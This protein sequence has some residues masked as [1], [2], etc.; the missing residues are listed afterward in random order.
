MEYRRALLEK[1]NIAQTIVTIAHDNT[2]YAHDSNRKIRHGY[3]AVFIKISNLIQKNA[4]KEDIKQYLD[5]VE[6]WK[7]FVEGE[8]KKSNETNNRSLG[9][10]Q[11]R[12]PNNEE[13]DNDNN[14]EVNMEKIMARF[15]NFN[16]MVSSS[17]N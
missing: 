9:G 2:N 10:H 7:E 14:Y 1:S 12:P 6:G 4:D 13:D 3:M 8:L 11:P 16:S 17:S 5:T 15:T